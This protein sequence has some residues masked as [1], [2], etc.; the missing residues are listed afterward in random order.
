[1]VVNIIFTNIEAERARLGLSKEEISNIL[2]ITPKTYYN[3]IYGITPIPS[4]KLVKLAKL[5]NVSLD[6]LL[7]TR[8]NLER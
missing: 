3:W 4:T 5:F 6:Y 1:M 2:V 8:A 7:E